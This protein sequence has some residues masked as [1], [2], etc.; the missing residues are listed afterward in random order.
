[1]QVPKLGGVG[2]DKI[3]SNITLNELLN[4]DDV[5]FRQMGWGAIQIHCWFEPEA[6]LLSLHLCGHKGNHLVNYF[7]LFIPFVETDHKF[8][9]TII[10]KGNLTAL[11]Q[12]QMAMVG[13][14]YCTTYGEYWA[15]HFA[16]ELSLAGFTITSG[17]ALGIDGHCHQAVVNIQGQTIAVLGSGLEQIYPSK[18]QRLSAQIIENNGALVS[19][20]LQTKPLLPLISHVV[21][22]LLAGFQS[23]HLLLKPQKKA[24]RLLLRDMRWNKT[25]RFLL[26]R[27]HSK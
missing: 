22:G 20:F 19:E 6:N 4:Y 5:A 13:S 27:K 17:L 3:L 26:C 16:T 2:I 7:P 23:A 11:S 15:K 21:I 9:A 10:C 18:H 24:A 25:E 1:M 8:S 14:R 12:R